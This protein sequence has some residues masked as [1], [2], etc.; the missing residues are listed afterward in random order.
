LDEQSLEMTLADFRSVLRSGGKLILQNRNF[1]QVMKNRS[2]WMDPQTYREG[3]KT[4]L[5]ARFYDFDA[6]NRL[7]F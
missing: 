1:D 7:T 3:D 6:D 4:W 2:R 5:F